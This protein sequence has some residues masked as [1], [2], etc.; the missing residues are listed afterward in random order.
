MRVDLTLAVCCILPTNCGSISSHADRAASDVGPSFR[1]QSEV[2]LWN[3]QNVSRCHVDILGN[4]SV[5]NQAR[6]VDAESLLVAVQNADDLRAITGGVFGKA[7]HGYHDV[8]HGEPR[9]V[10]DRL[11]RHCL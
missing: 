5:S 9:A 6:Q 11:G 7:A 10:G 4:I 3:D 2:A 1:W 8:E